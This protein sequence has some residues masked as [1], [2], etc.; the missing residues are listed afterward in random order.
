MEHCYY[1]N[2]QVSKATIALL[3][4]LFKNWDSQ[5]IV[6]TVCCY[7]FIPF[8]LLI[9]VLYILSPYKLSTS[10]ISHYYN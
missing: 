6:P 9:L 8:L 4:D 10:V 1:E 2:I 5:I 3:R 7:L